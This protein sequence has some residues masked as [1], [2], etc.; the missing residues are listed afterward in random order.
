MKLL[1]S[2]SAG[3]TSQALLALCL[4]LPLAPALLQA[5]SASATPAAPASA[6]T[7]PRDAWAYR[8]QPG[9]TL[10]QLAQTYLDERHGW[11]DLQR[12]NRVADPYK[13]P[14]GGVLRLP[15]AWLQRESAVARVLH[16]RG[17]AQL[18]RG[19]A[20]AAPLAAG[21]TLLPGDR[22][23]TGAESS[24]SLRFADGSRLLLGADS[25]LGL[26]QLLVQGRGALTNTQLRLEQGGADSRVEPGS[27]VP[28][29]YELRTPSLNLGVRGT[30]F[31]VQAEAGRTA[32]QVL[33]GRV[34]ADA[35][36]R[37]TALAAGQGA[38]AQAGSPLQVQAL[39]APPALPSTLRAEQLPLRL[40]WAATPQA[41][42]YRVQLFA[43]QDFDRLLLDGRVSTPEIVWPQA[44]KLPDG[45][46]SL[47]LRSIDALGLEGP[48]SESLL[49][50]KARPEP[51]LWLAPGAVAYGEALRLQWTEPLS[52]RAYRLQLADSPDFARP[53]LDRA[54][55]DRPALELP[56]PPGRYWLRLASLTR[57]DDQGPFGPPLAVELRPLP[58]SP[59]AREPDLDGDQLRLRW[60]AQPGLRYQLQWSTQADFGDAPAPRE[61]DGDSLLLERPAPGRYYLRLRGLDAHGQAGPWG[62]AQRLELPDRRWPWLLLLPALLL[63][64]L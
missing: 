24:L 30:E 42:A 52:A 3:R 23:Q 9:D 33:A 61:V 56:L 49:Q 4:T 25:L 31:R 32:V 13:L 1:P 8:I 64:A 14:P 6:A 60:V 22:L 27:T 48:A 46:Y 43:E 7:S 28:P 47:R 39:P 55:L 20:S 54:D 29:R 51:P 18:L 38:L 17:Q 16:V 11:Q 59:A 15:L 45:R 34:A 10:I 63:L 44:A 62:E 19:S 41:R 50:L 37:P 36:A 40:S 53:L 26:E 12:L 58:P 57:P 35:G 2:W 5:Q 21:M